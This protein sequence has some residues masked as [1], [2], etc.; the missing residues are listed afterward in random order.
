[1]AKLTFG[2]ALVKRAPKP[3]RKYTCK[4]QTVEVEQ[5]ALLGWEARVN[6]TL[7]KKATN[8]VD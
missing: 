6:V 8:R 7:V 1:M 3:K 4:L 5:A 2:K